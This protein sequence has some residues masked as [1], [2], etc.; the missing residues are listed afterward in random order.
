MARA[1]KVKCPD[2]KEEIEI[3]ASP[4]TGDVF[5]CKNCATEIELVQVNP[6]EVRII[7]EEK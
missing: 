5:E 3:G 2:C 1:M 7:E 6:P 4:M